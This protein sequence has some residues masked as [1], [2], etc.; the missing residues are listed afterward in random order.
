MIK[1]SAGKNW[2][3]FLSMMLFILACAVAWLSSVELIDANIIR[4]VRHSVQF[5]YPFLLLAMVA[6]PLQQILRKPWTAKLL[7]RRRLIGVAFAGAMTAHLILIVFSLYLYP[8]ADLS[9]AKSA[10]R[11]RCLRDVVSDV[12]YVVRRPDTCAGPQKMEAAA[13]YWPGLRG[14]NIR[15][16]ANHCRDQRVRIPE[17]RC[18]YADRYSYPGGSVAAIDSARYVTLSRVMPA[19]LMR[20]ESTM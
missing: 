10:D 13:S 2:T 14:A 7:R 11:R 19:T 20:L 5:A 16:T 3:V 6:R 9:N 17:T 18:T 8:G 1:S 4:P 15:G 12:H